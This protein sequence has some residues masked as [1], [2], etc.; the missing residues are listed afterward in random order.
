MA[1]A[2]LA[3]VPVALLLVF[4]GRRLVESLNFTGIK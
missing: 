1:A 4:F 3:V 2:V